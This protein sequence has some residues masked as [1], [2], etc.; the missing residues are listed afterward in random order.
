[1]NSIIKAID[2]TIAEQAIK[3]EAEKEQKP[4]PPLA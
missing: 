2:E 1:M 3:I 4:K